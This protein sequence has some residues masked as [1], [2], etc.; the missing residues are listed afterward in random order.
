MTRASQ[1][2]IKRWCCQRIIILIFVYYNILIMNNSF[3]IY[4][5]ESS[6]LENDNCKFMGLGALS[7][8]TDKKDEVFTRIREFKEQHG[9]AKNFEIKWTKV[10]D[11]KVGFYMDLVDYFFDVDYLGF[12]SIIINKATLNHES[13]KS[14]HDEFY[15]KM[16]F[17]L[18]RELLHTDKKYKIYLDKKDTKG[19]KKIAKLHHFLSNKNYDYKK[20][21]VES[22]QEV[23]SDQIELVQIC[24]L[25]L[26]AVCYANRGLTTNAGKV[27]IVKRIQERSGY[28]LIKNTFPSEFKMNTLIW[29]RKEQNQNEK[30]E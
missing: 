14:N 19:K 20:D 29:M 21:I 28:S 18:I 30:N 23:V 3:S 2:E 17:L 25:L 8:P 16:N 22:V 24:D 6:H 9:L 4:C 27:K 1:N 10:S 7:C 15:Y 5:D 11:S 26:G 12:R 13:S